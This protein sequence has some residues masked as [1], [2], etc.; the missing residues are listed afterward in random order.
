M[1][2]K[3]LLLSY[4]AGEI[5]KETLKSQLT[6][7]QAKSRR[8]PLTEGQKGLWAI[9]QNKPASNAYHVPVCLHVRD[10]IDTEKVAEACRAVVRA[11]P[12]LA[13]RILIEGGE[14]L[15]SEEGVALP[16]LHCIDV[17][18]LAAEEVTATIQSYIDAPFNLDTGPLLK[19]CLFSRSATDHFLL[20]V[21]HHIAFDGLSAILF[22]EQ[23]LEQYA[24][25]GGAALKA[26]LRPRTSSR[27][28]AEWEQA[29]LSGK[30]VLDHLEFWAAEY[31]AGMPATALPGDLPAD[32]P[33]AVGC[34][35][36]S[37]L[38]DAALA[39]RV[40][41][42]CTQQEISRSTLFLAL[43]Q[44]LLHRQGCGE[45]IV[46][47]M[48]TMVRPESRFDEAIGYFVNTLPVCVRD[49]SRLTFAGLV[50]AASE[51][52]FEIADHYAYP[53]P[54]MVRDLGFRPDSQ[55]AP[56]FRII[57]AYQNFIDA[58]RTGRFGRE[59]E[60][61]FRFAIADQFQ[62]GTDY[63]LALEVCEKRG[64]FE[65]SLKYQTHQYSR[66]S[67]DRLLG[68][69][70]QLMREHLVAAEQPVSPASPAGG[71][72]QTYAAPARCLHELFTEKARRI[73][74]KVALVGNGRSYTYA[75][76]DALTDAIAVRLLERGLEVEAR[77]A[78]CMDRSVDVVLAI[79]GVLKAGGAYVPLD[80]S[81]PEQRLAQVLEDCRPALV[82][83]DK[84]YAGKL[85]ATGPSVRISTL[86]ALLTADSQADA[87]A[88]LADRARPENLAYILYT[89][90]STGVP[91]GVMVEHRNV[92]NTLLAL[93][94]R[95][96][97]TDQS[98]YL[99]K[100]NY[101][102]DVSVA[103]IFGWFFGCGSLAVLPVGDE[104]NPAKLAAALVDN[105]ITHVNF[106]P[107]MLTTFLCSLNRADLEAATHL[108]YVFVAGE[109]FTP[110]LLRW[111]DKVLPA[112]V[113][114]ENIYGP[115]EIAIYGTWYSLADLSRGAELVPIGT[116]L[117]NVEAY[118]LDE[119][120]RQV[121]PGADGELCI[122]GPGVARGYWNKPELSQ[123]KFVANPF[124]PQFSMY[125]TGDLVR[126]GADGN[127]LYLGRID[128]QVK[129][130]GYRIEIGAIETRLLE[131]PGIDQCA[132]VVNENAHSRKLVAYYVENAEGHAPGKQQLREFASKTL[133]EYMVPSFFI[134]L[135][136]LPLTST[137]KIDRKQLA[138]RVIDLKQQVVTHEV[139]SFEKGCI[140]RDL[141]AIWEQILNV[142]NVSV[143][144]GFF[145]VGGDSVNLTMMIKAVNEKYHCTLDRTDVFEH[146]DIRA[147][148]E[149]ILR[150]K[151][152]SAPQERAPVARIHSRP[153]PRPVDAA[154]T[155]GEAPR[156][157]PDYYTQCL[158]IVGISGCF[159]AA[160]DIETFWRNLLE[161]RES[162]RVL[163]RE[164]L[165]QL[166]LDGRLLDQPNYVPVLSA[167]ENKAGFDPDFFNMTPRDATLLDPQYRQLLMHAWNALEDAGY[168]PE[169]A[170][171]TGVFVSAGN[172]FYHALGGPSANGAQ[173]LELNAYSSWVF[174]QGGTA[175]TMISH[176]LGLT[177]PSLF[178]HTNCS[179]SLSAL[180]AAAKAILAGECSFALV[181]AASV[182]A[183][184]VPGYIH[185]P[186]MNFSA[187]GRLRAFAADADGMV[188]GEGAAVLLLKRAD[189][190]VADG[191]NIY[192]IVRGV[193]LNNDGND[194]VG[195]Y[196]PGY[197]G[198]ADVI[199]A[200]LRKTG[201][202]PATIEYVEAHGTGTRLGDPVEVR[203]LSDVYGRHTGQRQYCGLGSVK[204]NIGHLD[205]AA[206]LAGL[207]KVALALKHGVIPP[208][209]NCEQPNPDIKFA[210]S[211][212]FLVQKPTPFDRS[213]KVRRA[214]LSSFGLGG[215]NTHAILE[216]C[217][218]SVPPAA[219]A[220]GAP[221]IIPL[222]ART[223]S[224]LAARVD[225]LRAFISDRINTG[226]DGVEALTLESLAYTLQVG[227]A[228]LPCRCAFVVSTLEELLALM[229]QYLAQRPDERRTFASRA[230]DSAGSGAF[231]EDEDA[232]LLFAEW[233][234]QGRWEKLAHLWASG[235]RCDW[236]ALWRQGAPRR[237]SLPT[238]PFSRQPLWLKA[239]RPAAAVLPPV[240]TPPAAPEVPVVS[241]AAAPAASVSG[242]SRDQI[243]QTVLASLV[244]ATGIAADNFDV[245]A[246]LIE[247]GLDSLAFLGVVKDVKDRFEVE[248][249]QTQLFD[250]LST[251]DKIAAHV[252]GRL[253]SAAPKSGAVASGATA[254]AAVAT[255][256][257][258]SPATADF[259]GAYTQRTRTSK[260]MAEQNRRHLA[261][262]RAVAG[263]RP[264]SK[265]MVYPIVGERAEGARFHDVDGNEYLDIS[266]GFGVLLFGHKPDFVE[267]ALVAQIRRGLQ[268]GPQAQLA[269]ETAR[270]LCE[271][272][273]IDRVAFCNTGS[274]AVMVALRIARAAS[275]K[276]GIALFRN[277]YHGHFDGVLPTANNALLE[278][279]FGDFASLER[280]REKAGEIGVVLVEPVQ[281]RRPELQPREFLQTLRRLTESLQIPL[282]F[283]EVLT[284]FRI[285]AGGAQ[286]WYGIKA[287]L[288]TY[289]KIIGGGLPV[290]AVGGKAAFMNLIDGGQ[291]SFSDDSYPAADR[292]MFVG[293]YNKNSLAMAA[294]H[295]VL[296]EIK[297]RGPELYRTLNDRAAAFCANLNQ[298]FRDLA[299]PLE[300]V[301]FGSLFRFKSA[302]NLEEFYFRLIHQGVY[303]WEGR[304]CFLATCMDEAFL[305]D[306]G[307]RIGAAALAALGTAARVAQPVKA[308]ERPA[309][310]Q[311]VIP[312]AA[313]PVVLAEREG[314]Y[315]VE[316]L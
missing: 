315:A 185:Q 83:A 122:S 27:D 170:A 22:T 69:Y 60:G 66:A 251:L 12:V 4:R 208:T 126:M 255:G 40:G 219:H 241:A 259:P 55:Q 36:A 14:L 34:G 119:Q 232:Q 3:E 13:S 161:G 61:P 80:P 108:Q 91:K 42:F 254:P 193:A 26:E 306:L 310:A 288:V 125:K 302:Q 147:L 19:A 292:V 89:S 222:S 32:T 62:Q 52:V 106:V 51:K 124:N 287:D 268:I 139:I 262:S 231:Y 206:G 152:R 267:Q 99:F 143:T 63:D 131:Y 169:T 100:T 158:A 233:Q 156:E 154:E 246:D 300:V 85:S 227:R 273:G 189:K 151:N 265:Q 171:D 88:V 6:V 195:F 112:H 75:E 291:W 104:S 155:H 284:G 266:M 84:R 275:G 107:S 280:L 96:P 172:S 212:F 276:S 136:E 73:P 296:S 82:L 278:L 71:Q 253:G 211:P 210:E 298:Q 38:L 187:D 135:P 109:A 50:R 86:E 243:L 79:L 130:R 9:A 103:E 101:I 198:Q 183:H 121:A 128:H 191:D 203:A 282:I 30:N 309:L 217:V 49:L 45:T 140:E 28:F 150:L 297:R 281:S 194:K 199:E 168:S 53:F 184:D 277:S 218:A 289:G 249:S 70:E 242:P 133:P 35:R 299:L 120:G 149:H 141:S 301:N 236:P 224:Q 146:S 16:E 31:R 313:A 244:S 293:T 264:A 260:H 188:V 213:R 78:L 226:A 29:Y 72:T 25:S 225:Q 105:K 174:A 47:G 76:V 258:G 77:V 94:Q 196:A 274:E 65:L 123:Q 159:P 24:G 157:V 192:A 228:Q 90:G 245:H 235:A 97:M 144:D 98:C 178:V 64:S 142:R 179:S 186:G 132:V 162:V 202:D 102:F 129:I 137:G 311:P 269:G 148:A 283:D 41:E 163:K 7:L 166:G 18:G 58:S 21:A 221:Q 314:G 215:T 308:P 240:H 92:L 204:S 181:G 116:P 307:A 111:C 118:I 209:I 177:G 93:E 81:H 207:V 39:R 167:I 305:A 252:A 164:E 59:I 201:V 117:P 2:Y 200:C 87:A 303:V 134:P 110:H 272:T 165:Q 270:L 312:A 46:V 153:A 182:L 15:F 43:W 95:Y 37:L 5:T 127:I 214:A 74:G 113:Q 176:K 56:V 238:Y 234:R 33:A 48:P 23:F 220:V 57:Y 17:A 68:A 256:S 285:A 160:D 1:I 54:R 205:A 239:E 8:T 294:S 67:I 20:F 237:L 229:E 230:A 263:L 290:A 173:A 10:R 190:A 115:T 216:S 114:V 250:E 145:D 304:N 44:L 271:L 223:V 279:D 180:D 175:P 248:I 138:E 316:E 247:M 261:D 197:R 295:A 11:N 257:P 286:E